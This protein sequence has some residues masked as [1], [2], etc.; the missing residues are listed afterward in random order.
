VYP[1]S[2]RFRVDLPSKYKPTVLVR[3]HAENSCHSV[4]SVKTLEE[5]KVARGCLYMQ[6]PVQE[7]HSVSHVLFC[8]THSHFSSVHCNLVSLKR[9]RNEGIMRLWTSLESGKKKGACRLPTWARRILDPHPR[10]RA[11]VRG[12]TPSDS[13]CNIRS[14]V[15]LNGLHFKL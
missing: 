13:P 8:P 5:A 1:Q 6:M 2:Q 14:Q 3:L 10:L 11:A 12:A 15:S 9:Y 7:V 4:S